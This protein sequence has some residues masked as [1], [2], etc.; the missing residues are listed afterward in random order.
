MSYNPGIPTANQTFKETQGPINT[1]FTVANTAFGVDHV[2]F[3]TVSNQGLHKKV[4]LIP[5][6]DPPASTVGPIIYSKPEPYGPPFSVTKNE[7]FL[8]TNNPGS[9]IIKLTQT[10]SGVTIATKGCSFLPGGIIIQW[11]Q[12]TVTAN[13]A[14]PFSFQNTFTNLFSI[15]IAAWTT[16]ITTRLNVVPTVSGGNFYSNNTQNASY[17]AIGN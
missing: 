9:T 14:N 10:A 17:V 8:E 5:G 16:D 7:I 15:S 13:I 1:N 12:V 6:G 3:Q 2:N 4:T 11:G